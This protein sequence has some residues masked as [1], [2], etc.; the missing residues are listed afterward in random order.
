MRKAHINRETAETRIRLTLTLEGMT[1]AAPT[2]A[3]D[4]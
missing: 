1:A 4:F 3:A 2:P